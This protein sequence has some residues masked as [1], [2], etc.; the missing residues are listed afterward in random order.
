MPHFGVSKQKED[1]LLANMERLG[2]K[3]AQL[4]EKFVLGGGGGG[5]KQNKTA[6]CVQLKYSPRDIEVKCQRS[7]SQ[8]LNRYYARFELCDRV[9]GQIEGKKSARQQKAEK[10]RRQKR[11]RS[12]R[13]KARMLEEK[14]KKSKKKQLRRKPRI[15]D[16]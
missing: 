7:R 2:I 10:I 11:R 6:S 1:R 14:R 9:E 3:E 15:P 12:R 4:E 8:A 13:Q 5:Q 16:E